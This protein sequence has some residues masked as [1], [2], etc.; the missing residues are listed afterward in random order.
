[1]DKSQF[2][3]SL[4]ILVNK[5]EIVNGFKSK[6]DVLIWGS[7]ITP[8][9]NF[10]SELHDKFAYFLSQVNIL[11]RGKDFHMS[12]IK[13]MVKIVQSAIYKLE[14]TPNEDKVN[15]VNNHILLPPPLVTLKWLLEHVP[16]KYWLLLV[17]L[18]ISAFTLGIRFS[19]T[20]LYKSLK[21]PHIANTAAPIKTV[22]TKQ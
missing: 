14:T 5:P 17:G 15:T 11:G 13:D 20:N 12:L 16:W 2:I 7:Q 22:P 8:L 18:L 21:I 9:L 19:E 10:D 3:E 4:N 6:Q 1:M